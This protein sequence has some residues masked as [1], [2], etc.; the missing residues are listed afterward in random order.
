MGLGGG[1][2]ARSHGSLANICVSLARS[3]LDTCLHEKGKTMAVDKVGGG[4]TQ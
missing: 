1:W 3:F 4:Q 2:P